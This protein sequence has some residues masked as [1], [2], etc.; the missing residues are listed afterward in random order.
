MT[1]HVST[2]TVLCSS[3][4]YLNHRAGNLLKSNRMKV[5]LHMLSIE[6]ISG[7]ISFFAVGALQGSR[8]YTK[9][10]MASLV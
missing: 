3:R 9:A 2:G 4:E 6:H 8:R 10:P 7:H 1:E 5:T